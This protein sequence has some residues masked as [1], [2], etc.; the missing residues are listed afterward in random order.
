[1]RIDSGPTLADIRSSTMYGTIVIFF[2]S[3]GEQVRGKVLDAKLDPGLGRVALVLEEEKTGLI[4]FARYRY[5]SSRCT[6]GDIVTWNLRRNEIENVA[7]GSLW[8]KCSGE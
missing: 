2:N 6:S 7:N 3:C 8:Q 4:W 5:C 1:M